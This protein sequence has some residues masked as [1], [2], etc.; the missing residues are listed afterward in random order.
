MRRRT[1]I[2]AQNAESRSDGCGGEESIESVH[3]A[4][5]AGN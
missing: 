5:V 1:E 3:D 2:G 4:A